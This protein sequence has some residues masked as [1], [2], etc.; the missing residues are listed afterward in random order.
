MQTAE[1]VS[2]EDLSD[3]YVFQRSLLAYLKAAEM[4]HGKVLEVGSGMGYGV[5]YLAPEVEE[6]LAVDKFDS[7]VAAAYDHVG[8]RQMSVPPLTG[9]KKDYYDCVVS[10]QVI[11]HIEDDKTFVE[12]IAS[13]LKPGGKFIVT[14][15]NKPMSITRNPW[16]VRE[17]TI[18][19]L[20]ELLAGSFSHVEALG[21]FGNE[22]INEYYEKN[23]AAVQKITRWDVL[24]LQHRLPRRILQIPYD[25]LNRMNRKKLLKQNTDLVSD[26]SYEDYYIAEAAKGAFDLFYIATK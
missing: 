23:K 25:I 18:E 10:F 20:K 1:R 17:Y 24:D 26:I 3:N 7:D 21:V 14:T 5:K 9:I 16:H 19:E 8:F 13:V 15:P 4:V 22:A 6:Y 11:E 12:E 2:H